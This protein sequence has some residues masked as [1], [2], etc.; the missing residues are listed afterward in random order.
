MEYDIH[1]GQEGAAPVRLFWMWLLMMMTSWILAIIPIVRADDPEGYAWRLAGAATFFTA[2]FIVPLFRDRP[3]AMLTV[4]FTAAAALALSL[5][6]THTGEANLYSLL[7]FT[8]LSREAAY[9]LSGPGGA[10]IGALLFAGAAA[11]GLLGYPGL[12]LPF[13][14]LYSGLLAAVFTLYKM[15]SSRLEEASARNVA[16]LSEY[17]N[18]KRRLVRDEQNAR[19]EARIQVGREIHDTVGHKLTALLM[20]LEVQRMQAVG[21]KAEMWNGLK[22][23]AKESLDET[24]NAVKHLSKPE[25]AGLPAIMGLLR[26]LEAEQLMRIHF[27][28][29]HGALTA[30]LGNAQS[31]AVYRS[32]QEAITNAMKHGSAREVKISFEAPAGEIFRFE[33]ANP[34]ER[35]PGSFREGYG[36]MSMRERMKEAG[37]SLEFIAYDHQFVV[38]GTVPMTK[39]GEGA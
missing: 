12:P 37:G 38:R 4:M 19:Q 32:V 21:V 23:L 2:Y 27:T 9:R 14:S 29:K 24:R 16:L 22:Q 30:P 34:Y 35:G 10:A 6:P 17:R 26:R 13:I 31:I 25:L 7:A 36:L 11:P 18:M 28:A 39:S 3:R 15:M 33:V 20:Q 1:L 5:W 8:L